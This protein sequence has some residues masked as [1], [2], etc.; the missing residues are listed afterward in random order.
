[1]DRGIAFARLG[2]FRRTDQESKQRARLQA[3]VFGRHDFGL[4]CGNCPLV[5][6][7]DPPDLFDRANCLFD[8]ANVANPQGSSPTTHKATLRERSATLGASFHR[9]TRR[10]GF[11]CLV[12]LLPDRDLLLSAKHLF[13]AAIIGV[14]AITPLRPARQQLKFR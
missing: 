7:A 4:P 10:W 9:Y 8:S 14:A 2:V 11:R 6:A 5:A 1:M 12:A 13:S 3:V